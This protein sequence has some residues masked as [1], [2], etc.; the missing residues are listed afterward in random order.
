MEYAAKLTL[1]IY[2]WFCIVALIA[3]LPR[4]GYFFVAFKKQKRLVN[5]KK[6][7]I[8]V[9]LPARGESSIISHCL[10]SLS[11]QTYDPHC[12]DVHIVIADEADSTME[13]AAAYERTYVTVVSEQTCKGNALDGVLK[14]ILTESPDKYDAFL[15]VDADSLAA[16]DLLEEMNNALSSGKQI[17]CGKKLVK[18][19]QSSLRDSRSFVSNCTALTWTQIDELGN[20]ARNALD[21]PITMIGN[22][23]LVRADIIKENNGWPYC[24]LTEDYEMTADAIV[25]GWSSMYYSYAKVYTEEATDTKTAFKRKMRWV[26]G[27]AECQREYHKRIV[28]KTFSGGIKW[29][30][31]DFMYSTYPAYTFFGVS[32]VATIFGIVTTVFSLLGKAVTLATALRMALVP[33]AFIYGTLFAF[34][35]AAL[36]A[37]WRNIKIPLHEKLTVLF[38]NPIYMF[39]Y[40]RIFITAFLTN[41]DYYKW[42]PTVRIPF[43]TV[44]IPFFVD[45]SSDDGNER[46]HLQ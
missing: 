35:L 5:L 43:E 38:F 32:A 37:D 10:D 23:M 28:Q 42:E 11:A 17:I 3:Y 4:I 39:G 46:A 19:W 26:K 27:Y 22:G 21:I 12:F 8:A 36:L 44:Q 29:R 9:I 40:S 30:N 45:N 6:N 7:K 16:P 24:G 25:Q 15:I 20:R 14:K 33:L 18:N 31:F 1:E 34:T 41:F 2:L 13:I